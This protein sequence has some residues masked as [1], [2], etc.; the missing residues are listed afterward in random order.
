VSTAAD[1]R[2][3]LDVS[4]ILPVR[5]GAA[6]I[7]R[8]LDALRI[9]QFDGIWEILI[10]DNGST[11]E[12]AAIVREHAAIDDRIALVDASAV[13]GTAYARNAGAAAARGAKLVF[14][15]ADDVVSPGWVAALSAGLESADVVSGVSESSTRATDTIS[16]RRPALLA[17]FVGVPGAN[18]GVR[19]DAYVAI[20]GMDES[21]LRA[22]DLE[23]GVRAQR[24]GYR[25]GFA[26]AATIRRT[27]RSTLRAIARQHYLYGY[28]ERCI[29]TRHAEALDPP[30]FPSLRGWGWVVVRTPYL[31]AGRH[32]RRLVIG[33]AAKQYG[34]TRGRRHARTFTP[35]TAAR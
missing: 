20:G 34:W 3:G 26:P 28:W 6:T 17:P 25:L 2:P 9:Q 29:A 12:T 19:R 15:D 1:D 27:P 21:F 18:F 7:G 4:V 8:Q 5:N 35:V 32:R 16:E 10:A 11:D 22:Q 23:F 30:R 31:L 33:R 24:A 14:C 13:V